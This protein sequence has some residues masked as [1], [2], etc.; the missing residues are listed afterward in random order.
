[1][2][3][4]I[5]NK[6]GKS[7]TVAIL[8]LASL[9]AS[10]KT[11]LIDRVMALVDGD[12]VLASELVSRTNAVIS[13][14]K[15]RDQKLP[16][17]DKLRQQV[18]ERLIIESLQLQ[19]AKRVGVRVSDAE[20]D[21]TIE[22]VALENKIS[23]DQFRLQTIGEGTAWPIFREQIRNEIMISRVTNGMVS[24]RIQVNDKEVDNLLAQMN[25]EGQSRM[26][27]TLGHILLPLAEGSTPEAIAKVRAKASKLVNELRNG[28]NFEE[29]AIT[30]SAAQ[31]ALKGGN[32]GERSISQLPTLFAGSVKNMK[33]GDISEPLRS[34][35]GLHILHLIELKGGVKEHRVLQTHVRHILI[36]PDAITDE[37][38]ARERLE[39]IRQK[40]IDGEKFEDL[41]I[42]FSDDK[43]S[44][45]LGGD[46]DWSDPD[47]FVPIFEKTMNE[48]AI[49]ELS[50]PVKSDFGWH[51]IEVLGR[52]DQD[53]TEEK[54]R[55][56]AYRILQNRKFEEE[57]QV[58]VSEMKEQAYIKYIDEE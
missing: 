50:E 20:L 56:H 29:Y 25:K 39:L 16:E 2:N 17:I 49:N 54:K 52:R 45:S 46:L 58:W 6:V 15:Q 18:L 57:A 19:A 35:S 4:L 33:A 7:V 31:D 22:K 23:V 13:Q 34:G 1:M 42:E 10:A 53:H 55:E 9:L 38:A 5:K 3:K 12:V 14:I 26:R 51:L 28:A 21:A 27:Y 8:C 36:T 32:L 24:R 41:A 11:E 40:I 43:G 37:K 30:H 44:G 47:T 48:L